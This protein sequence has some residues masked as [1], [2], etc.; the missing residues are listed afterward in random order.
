MSV[1]S[2]T[3]QKLWKHPMIFTAWT[4]VSLKG[5]RTVSEM[6]LSAACQHK[7]WITSHLNLDLFAGRQGLPNLGLNSAAISA[8]TISLFPHEYGCHWVENKLFDDLSEKTGTFKPEATGNKRCSWVHWVPRHFVCC[9][10][11]MKVGIYQAASFTCLVRAIPLLRSQP[12]AMN[13]NDSYEYCQLTEIGH[14][15]R[16]A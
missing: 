11:P 13:T 14:F 12:L 2:R 8:S 16:G 7:A 4:W 15:K 3:G 5:S 1:G 10:I 6:L 9:S